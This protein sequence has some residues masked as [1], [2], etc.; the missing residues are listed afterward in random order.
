VLFDVVSKILREELH[1]RRLALA[2]G[3]ATLSFFMGQAWAQESPEAAVKK[4][5][6]DFSAAFNKH[7]S[8]A[9]AA[10]FTQD[11]IFVPAN[12]KIVHGRDEIRAYHQKA[13]EGGPKDHSAPVLEVH[14]LKPA[15]AVYALGTFGFAIPKKDGDLIKI[16]GNW[17]AVDVKDGDQWRI[18]LLFASVPPPPPPAAAASK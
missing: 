6:T 13:F 18:K 7:D 12:G 2:V 1:M 11:G 17:T 14:Q 3:F 16:G 9:I 8:E 4:L 15:D 5:A 10:L